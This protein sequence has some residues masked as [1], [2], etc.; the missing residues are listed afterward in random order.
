MQV[1]QFV[2]LF[3]RVLFPELVV[4]ASVEC[5]VTLAW[6][7][8]QIAAKGG[9]APLCFGDN[10]GVK[11][12]RIGQLLVLRIKAAQVRGG[13]SGYVYAV[14]SV[15]DKHSNTNLAWQQ[16]SAYYGPDYARRK[17]A[18]LKNPTKTNTLCVKVESVLLGP[19]GT[20]PCVAAL[21]GKFN[22]AL[23]VIAIS[24][25]L[26]QCFRPPVLRKRQTVAR[27]IEQVTGLPALAA[28]DAP[29]IPADPA[30]VPPTHAAPAAHWGCTCGRSF[31]SK[32]SRAS[33]FGGMNKKGVRHLH[34]G[35]ETVQ[36]QAP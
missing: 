20:L 34:Q 24:R 17:Q 30:P 29:A 26:I 33:H 3:L 23:G 1:N 16:I 11:R 25:Y 36:P 35:L 12:I 19:D 4:G 5:I 28:Y 21:S 7:A 32:A 9:V 22:F 6:E 18:F 27:A 8:Q 31:P 14:V 13:V 2:A 10:P 15:A